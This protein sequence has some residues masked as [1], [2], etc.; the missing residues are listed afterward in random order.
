MKRPDL[1]F[2]L[3][4]LL[5]ALLLYYPVFYT[6]YLYSDEGG[7]LWY[8]AKGLN[9]DVFI[10]QGRYFTYLLFTGVFAS[11]HTIHDLIHARLFSFFGWLLC[12]P[13]WYFIIKD[14]LTRNG[15]PKILTP[16]ALIYLISMPPF[17]ISIGWASCMEL[18]VA[19]TAGLVSGYL[20]YTG[21]IQPVAQ[22][23]GRTSKGFR[24]R[25]ILFLTASLLFGLLS[26]FTYQSGFGCF[27]LP[28]LLV[29]I[30]EKK[31]GRESLI[32]VGGCLAI[33]IVYYLLFRFSLHLAGLQTNP[34]GQFATDPWNKLLFLFARPL[35]S[36]FHFTWLTAPNGIPGMLIYAI[37]ALSVLVINFYRQ[38]AA[39]LVQKFSYLAGLLIFPILIYLPS[40]IVKE[41]Y[42]SNRTLLA[43]DMAVFLL[44]GEAFFTGI[45]N[46]NGGG[47]FPRSG[48]ALATTLAAFFLVNAWYNFNAGFR[49]PLA[50]E[51][52]TIK[53]F[54]SL[55]YTPRTRTVYFICASE[56]GFE[57]KYGIVASWDEF[58]VP[59]TAKSWTPEPMI[60]QLILEK[61]GSRPQTD[62]IIVKTYTDEKFLDVDPDSLRTTA[63]LI[64][65]G[66]LLGTPQSDLP[67]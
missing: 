43:L 54:V 66:Y 25:T 7:N 5:A 60:R 40:L 31:I 10:T 49:Q 28:F 36:A 2:I 64:N 39:P 30:S 38:R 50:A 11:I 21:G 14:L 45:K 52:R 4:L 48:I 37:L 47:L 23:P 9:F 35:A 44:A 55:H 18:F 8:G 62:S 46:N 67:W 17:A 61:T 59:S 41:N 16:L 12:L 26:L 32:G 57:E 63:L 20:L 34:R 29:F 3:F 13:P 65:A 22:D 58:G 27:L 15:L 53:D 56:R 51:Y 33:Y 19:C 42:A 24:L 1:L 6:D